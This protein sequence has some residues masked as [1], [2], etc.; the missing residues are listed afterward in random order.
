MKDLL[1]FLLK[2]FYFAILFIAISKASSGA[3]YIVE[4]NLDE[5]SVSMSEKLHRKLHTNIKLFM[6]KSCCNIPGAPRVT[7][8]QFAKYQQLV[9][10]CLVY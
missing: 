5:V 9:S 8:K 4:S 7:Q 6:L 3:V 2:R 1:P 10:A